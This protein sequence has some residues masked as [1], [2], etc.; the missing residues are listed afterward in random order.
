[1]IASSA[2]LRSSLVI[3][4]MTSTCTPDRLGGLRRSRQRR[5]RTFYACAARFRRTVSP[6][7]WRRL[8]LDHFE[9]GEKGDNH[10]VARRASLEETDEVDGVVVA[11]QDL[12]AELGHH[13]RYG[14]FF[15]L[16]LDARDFFAALENLLEDANEVDHGDDQLA[17]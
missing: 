11:G 4:V 6:G 2:A 8:H 14:E 12:R 13:L 7:P 9:H 16:Q 17:F 10:G 3:V 15:V 1:M 5:Y